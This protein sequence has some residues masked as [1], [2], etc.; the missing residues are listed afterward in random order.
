MKLPYD[1]ELLR[2]FIGESYLHAARP[3]YA[4]IGEGLITREKANVVA[5]RHSSRD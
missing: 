4:V 2:I 1:A 5:Y 3:L